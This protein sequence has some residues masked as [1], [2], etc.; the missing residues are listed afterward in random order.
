[1]LKRTVLMLMISLPLVSC[2]Q[3][4]KYQATQHLM[5]EAPRSFFNNIFRL[6]Y[7]VNPGAWGGMLGNAPDILRHG[8]LT[9]GVG[10]FLMILAGYIIFQKQSTQKT[11]ALS[12]LLAGGVGN[13][14]DR[15]LNGQVVDFLNIG[16]GSLR[17]NIFN[18]ADVVALLGVGLMLYYQFKQGDETEAEPL[19]A[20]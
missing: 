7:A 6:E 15:A 2:D 17:T 16:I 4:T 9:Y 20:A 10:L 1:M 11:V 14:I 3:V 13:L 19:S 12:L 5:G 8:V 18:V